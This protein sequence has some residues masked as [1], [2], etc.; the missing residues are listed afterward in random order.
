MASV[1]NTT[2]VI[3]NAGSPK[4]SG[5]W[6]AAVWPVGTNLRSNESHMPNEADPGCPD[7]G[8]LFNLR[9]DRTEHNEYSLQFP[10]IKAKMS[11]RMKALMATTFQSDASF[12]GGY[13]DC[14]DQTAVSSKLHGFFGVCCSKGKGLKTEDEA[15]VKA[16]AEAMDAK[17]AALKQLTSAPPAFPFAYDWDKFPAAWFGGNATDFESE[18]QLEEIGKYSLAIFGWQHMITATN[19]T[20]SVYAQLEQAAKLKAKFPTMPVYVYS[21][22]GNADACELTTANV[23]TVE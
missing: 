2:T 14:K 1:A 7:G 22:F 10:E 6:T 5:Y 16:E 18:A 15:A 20:A 3:K 17:L 11:S 12:T 8:C 13:D 9:L 19:W 21:G 23:C 4:G